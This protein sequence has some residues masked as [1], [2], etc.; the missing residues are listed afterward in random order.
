MTLFCNLFMERPS[1]VAHIYCQFYCTLDGGWC[2]LLLT[3]NYHVLWP[4]R[5]LLSGLAICLFFQ[6]SAGLLGSLKKLQVDF[7]WNFVEEFGTARGRS[8][9]ILVVASIHLCIPYSE[10]HT[11]RM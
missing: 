9:Y 11:V 3:N 7:E 6:L 5:R 4:V 2:L 8:D 10:S 1:Y